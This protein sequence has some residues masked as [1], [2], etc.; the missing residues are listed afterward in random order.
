MSEETELKIMEVTENLAALLI[1]KNRRY[2][3]SALHPIKIFAKSSATDSIRVRLD[4][5]LSRLANSDELRKN[6]VYD[7]LGYLI[8]LCISR[9]W[10]GYMEAD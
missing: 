10:D 6:D 5:K 9:G 2:G 4:D 3:D 8:L 1:E 7:V